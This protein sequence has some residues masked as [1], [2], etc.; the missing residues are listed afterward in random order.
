[1]Q[2]TKLG[3]VD[4]TRFLAGLV[5]VSYACNRRMVL[6]ASGLHVLAVRRQSWRGSD[7]LLHLH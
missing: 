5:I 1:M 4:N 6:H 3:G 7:D 2:N